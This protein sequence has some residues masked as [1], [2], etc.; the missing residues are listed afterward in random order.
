MRYLIIADWD[1]NF[2]PNRINHKN[3]EVEAVAL[4]DRLV[5]HM[6]PGKEASNAFYVADPGIDVQYI[7]VD[8]AT[9][10]I[11]VDLDGE[12]ADKALQDW[13]EEMQATDKVMVA[14]SARA[15]EEFFDSKPAVLAK[16]PQAFQDN[17]ATRKT[18]RA[19]RP[20][21]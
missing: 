15:L 5:N 7:T 2:H 6:K 11:T 17:H 12:T 14:G 13:E 1:E 10:T 21:I 20:Q 3:T 4:V 18:L 19:R 8:P 16:K 9:K